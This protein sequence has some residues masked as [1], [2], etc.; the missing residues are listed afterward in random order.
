MGGVVRLRPAPA[1]WSP[2]IHTHTH[3]PALTAAHTHNYA[4]IQPRTS[5]YMHT[6][7]H[8]RAQLHSYL[9]WRQ[10]RG[11]M[12]SLRDGVTFPSASKM[13]AGRTLFPRRLRVAAAP[14]GVARR[15][16]GRSRALG[17]AVAVRAAA[18]GGRGR[19]GRREG[20]SGVGP[21]REGPGRTGPGRGGAGPPR[22]GERRSGEGGGR[23]GLGRG[24]GA[25]AGG[26]GALKGARRCVSGEGRGLR[27]AVVTPPLGHAPFGHTHTAGRAPWATA[28]SSALRSSFR[29]GP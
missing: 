10:R 18:G 25:C 27:G 16:R 26:G 24:G 13:A 29:P 19:R 8:M 20:R 11:V 4:H 9:S 17:A 23:V 12:T 15:G 5:A 3:T 7:L 14:N 28:P 1:R 2:K 6:R 22:P 21:V